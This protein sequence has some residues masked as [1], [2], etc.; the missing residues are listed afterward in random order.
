MNNAT[1]RQITIEAV[2]NVGPRHISTGSVNDV[3]PR[4]I[5]I[6]PVY[7][8]APRFPRACL[9]LP[10]LDP[11]KRHSPQTANVVNDT[12]SVG[13]KPPPMRNKTKE[14]SLATLSTR[15]P[16]A[17]AASRTSMPPTR[18]APTPKTLAKSFA[19]SKPVVQPTERV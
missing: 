17:S 3:V 7:N 15:E 19:E 2:N 1:A 9:D 18:R 11:P 10:L 8:A 13:K 5:P 6:A 14:P 4:Q 16:S 12:E